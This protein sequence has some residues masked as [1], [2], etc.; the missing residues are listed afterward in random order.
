MK[1]E[2]FASLPGTHFLLAAAASAVILT[3]NIVAGLAAITVTFFAALEF[4]N[5]PCRW[6][7]DEKDFTITM[8]GRKRRF[9][10][11]ELESVSCEYSDSQNGDAYAV[12][13]IKTVSGRKKKYVENV[14][15]KLEDI[16]N[17]PEAFDKPQLMQLCEYVNREMEAWK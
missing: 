17:Y 14:G 9:L 5:L 11:S 12:L 6:S 15:R 7:A 2:Y 4:D 10:Y 16:V 1:G 8:L 3:V 13:T